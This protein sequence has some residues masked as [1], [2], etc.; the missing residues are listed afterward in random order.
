MILNIL[1]IFSFFYL[2]GYFFFKKK[3]VLENVVLGSLAIYLITVLFSFFINYSDLFLLFKLICLFALFSLFLTN[4]NYKELFNFNLKIS[5]KLLVFLFF[6][7][8]IFFENIRN[9]QSEGLE[10]GDS[11]A[12]WFNK[13]K[14]FVYNPGVEYLPK[15]S[16]PN[17]LSSLWA[18]SF[19]LFDYDYNLSR[20][21]LPFIF[22]VVFTLVIQKIN[23]SYSSN[24]LNFN[25]VLFFIFLIYFLTIKFAGIYRFSNAGYADFALS[26][27]LMLGFLYL[28][29]SFSNK[30]FS[31]EDYLFGIVMLAFG[32]S[33]KNEGLIIS[34]GLYFI[35]NFIFLKYFY[36]KFKKNIS[37]LSICFIIFIA[38]SF[39][40][41]FLSM[42]LKSV[43]IS[44]DQSI[45]EVLKFSNFF[46]LKIVVT[47]IMIITKSLLLN[48][49]KYYLI[50]FILS[51][52][53]VFKF[54]FKF[55]QQP[56]FKLLIYLS[57]F[58]IIYIYSLYL[59]SSWDLSWHL[60]TS[61]NRIIYHF[62]GLFVCMIF[63]ILNSDAKTK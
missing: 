61:L 5:I 59:A 46:E 19:F 9:I 44:P 4:P 48:L 49:S 29:I 55:I 40:P 62:C 34:L 2:I 12:Y 14:F 51:A 11:L 16:Y 43:H 3:L 38:I 17:F 32:S 33:I 6:I 39:F 1:F 56:V 47:K 36:F 41:L 26:A 28:Y 45:W 52:V 23:A 63:L 21:V 8:L 22:M 57:I 58:F 20:V 53:I 42:Y 10:A 31:K 13:T 60:A 25:I 50:F 35:L 54:S 7:F 15:P 18:L 24:Y 37:Y 30:F 27:Y